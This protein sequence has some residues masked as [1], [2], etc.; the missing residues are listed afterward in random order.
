MCRHGLD[1]LR[2][3]ANIGIMNKSLV[4]VPSLARAFEPERA[5]LKKGLGGSDLSAAQIVSEARRALDRT[6]AKFAES[7]SDPQVHKAGL[8][9][10]EMVKAGAGILD[11]GTGAEI[12]WHEVPK[13]KK[14]GFGGQSLFYFGAGALALTALVQEAAIALMSV[15]ALVVLR[16]LDPEN[17]KNLKRKLPFAKKPL[18]IE[19]KSGRQVKAEARVTADAA[20]FVDSLSDA[21]RTADHILLRLA[22][23]Q[24]ETHWRQDT[25]LMGLVQALLEAR[26]SNDGD[27]ALKLIGAELETLLSAEGIEQVEYSKKTADLFDVL[28]GI[29][30]E[31]AKPAAPALVADGDVIKR[32]T[33][34]GS[35][36]G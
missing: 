4:N 13:E 36:S 11:Q 26:A 24:S 15:G 34:W 33:V 10:L 25:R 20:G 12:I 6:G 16:A 28:P 2:C 32:G 23:P 35:D 21:L 7:T 8:W 18:A 1:S 5:A 19:D 27:F 17:F 22:E 31:G 30:V 14:A 9:L 3:H 29:D